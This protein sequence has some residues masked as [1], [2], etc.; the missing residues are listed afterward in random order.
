MDLT[1]AFL[2]KV[3]HPVPPARRSN[4]HRQRQRP[5]APNAVRGRPSIA[6]K[7]RV[8]LTVTVKI[9]KHSGLIMNFL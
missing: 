4:R 5:Y 6:V 3:F 2:L 1:S 7:R 9:L 8:N